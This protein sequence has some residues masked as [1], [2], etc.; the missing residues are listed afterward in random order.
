MLLLLV[1]LVSLLV[2][3]CSLCFVVIIFIISSLHRVQ[4][5]RI[6]LCSRP[7]QARKRSTVQRWVTVCLGGA[8][9]QKLYPN[10]YRLARKTSLFTIQLHSTNRS[11]TPTCGVDF[12][13]S[14][15]D[16]AL[17]PLAPALGPL[18]G[19]LL[20]VQFTNDRKS[21]GLESWNR[22]KRW[23]RYAL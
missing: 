13:C 15:S 19:Q 23:P 12:R 10:S 21:K 9:K 7:R 22:F 1:V 5:W 2:L 18:S 16:G 4:T 11:E 20:W 8:A 17:W 14:L 3:T 6:L